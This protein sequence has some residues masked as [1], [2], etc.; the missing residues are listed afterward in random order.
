MDSTDKIIID[1][2]KSLDNKLENIEDKLTFL[3]IT[4]AKQDVNIT[5]NLDKIIDIERRIIPI[6]KHVTLVVNATRIFGGLG[7]IVGFFVSTLKALE[8][9]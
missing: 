5:Q 1:M 6:E 7:L 3:N 9:I 2:I 4:I 8:I